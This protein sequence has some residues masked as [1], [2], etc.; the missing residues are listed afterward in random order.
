MEPIDQ[1]PTKKLPESFAPLEE[2]RGRIERILDRLDVAD[3]STERADLGSELVR[4]TSRYEDVLERIAWPL[5]DGDGGAMR[6]L[7][8]DRDA[9]REAMIVIH[10]ATKHIDARNVHAPD[11][12][13]FEDALDVVRRDVRSI[14]AKEDD[15]LVAI[16]AAV[17]AP[18]EREQFSA[19]L[20]HAIHNA[21]ER[22]V[23]PK[24]AVGRFIT[25]ASVKLDKN[26]E[27]ASTPQHP[28]ADTIKE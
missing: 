8:G 17:S 3:D 7:E 20:D 23:P 24:T 11:P 18:E 28:A 2:E 15:I 19:D 25:N 27:D 10:D 4:S 13:G 14:L 16:D 1:S 6:Q 22:P 26:F 12:Q 9:L 5:C 21:S